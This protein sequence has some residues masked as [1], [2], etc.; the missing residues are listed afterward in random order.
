MLTWM[1]FQQ[2]CDQYIQQ[3]RKEHACDEDK[4]FQ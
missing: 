2:K 3:Q 1:N 4:F